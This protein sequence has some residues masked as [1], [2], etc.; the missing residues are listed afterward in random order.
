MLLWNSDNASRE[1]YSHLRGFHEGI[2]GDNLLIHLKYLFVACLKTDQ[3]PDI[4]IEQAYRQRPLQK[5]KAGVS[6]RDILA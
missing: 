1:N 6:I 3:D 5:D 2:E 4:S